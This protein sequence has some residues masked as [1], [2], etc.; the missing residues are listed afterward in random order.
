MMTAKPLPFRV[1]LMESDEHRETVL[2]ILN[3]TFEFF[4]KEGVKQ[5]YR[6]LN[7]LNPVAESLT[8][9]LVDTD[10]D[11]IIGTQSVCIREFV[12]GEQQGRSGTLIDFAVDKSYRSLG[13]AMQL[14]KGSTKS[15]ADKLSFI[16]AYPNPKAA[17]VFKRAGA[18][19]LGETRRMV[20]VLRG[21]KYLR[22]KVPGILLT[23][24]AAVLNSGLAMLDWLVSRSASG[25]YVASWQDTDNNALDELWQLAE[26]DG[27]L[28]S[29]RDAAV[30]AWRFRN[31]RDYSGLSRVLFRD[32]K[33]G[34]PVG[35]IIYTVDADTVKIQDFFMVR[36][37]TA[38]VIDLWRT[39]LWGI[40]KTGCSNVFMEFF[41]P[42][43]VRRGL[44]KVGFIRR[45]SAQVV[46]FPGTLEVP[47]SEENW[48]LTGFDR[49]T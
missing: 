11:K 48:Y 33:S 22:E 2:N 47:E 13:P 25:R 30:V 24:V 18:K 43:A 9:L 4:N 14:L 46:V 49:D 44:G 34:K 7:D 37:D 32:R 31:G 36:P 35:Y 27:V 3:D 19:V 15:S 26:F 41:G 12:L 29:R 28:L 39:F 6:W 20:R 1:D 23:P 17:P 40:R 42:E 45:E 38:L 16:Y 21:E 5:K 10:K 8:Y